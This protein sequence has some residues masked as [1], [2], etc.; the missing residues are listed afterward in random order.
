MILVLEIIACLS[1]FFSIGLLGSSLG[2]YCL[3]KQRRRSIVSRAMA[4]RGFIEW[5]GYYEDIIDCKCEDPTDGPKT[6]FSSGKTNMSELFDEVGWSHETY[7]K[8]VTRISR[9]E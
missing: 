3:N 4:D 9:S 8:P 6:N 7:D 1:L 2:S 5:P